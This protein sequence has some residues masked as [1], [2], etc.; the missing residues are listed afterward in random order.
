[1][2]RDGLAIGLWG[3]FAG[4]AIGVA[5]TLM[6]SAHLAE[7]RL[8]EETVAEARSS[9][10]T[11][12]TKRAA[13]RRPQQQA[14]APSPPNADLAAKD[15]TPVVAKEPAN[16]PVVEDESP[17]AG[18]LAKASP[19]PAEAGSGV[20][21]AARIGDPM[22]AERIMQQFVA[23]ERRMPERIAALSPL[24][25]PSAGRGGYELLAGPFGSPDER[26]QFCR[27]LAVLM[28]LACSDAPY[29]GDPIDL[30]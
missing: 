20:Q 2:G 16:K 11:P 23:I 1:M 14:K 6:Y 21:L 9:A 13:P 27:A 3:F 29:R 17:A 26:A 19:E 18:V 4:I 25:A 5:A 30:P 15:S 10:D 28:T 7:R 24:I 22:T 8:P 12:E